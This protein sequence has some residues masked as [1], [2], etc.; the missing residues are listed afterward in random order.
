M[1]E[2]LP[3][4]QVRVSQRAR[5]V[6]LNIT[7]EKGLI[8]TIPRGFRP[9]LLP[10]MLAEKQDWI[11]KTIEKLSQTEPAAKKKTL[12]AEFD[13]VSIGEKWQVVYKPREVKTVSLK[14]QA[15][16]VLMVEGR[17]TSHPA[18]RSLLRRWLHE[19]A[20]QVL[21]EWLERISRQLKLPY[22]DV[23]IRDQRTRW[24]SCSA[25]KNISLNQKLL[26][27]PPDLV[28]YILVHELCHTIQMSHSSNYWKLVGQIM[29]DYKE[30]RK[31]LRVYEK[32][33]EW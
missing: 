32:K 28:E 2:S 20:E 9:E 7:R 24:G 33:I 23:S 6:R 22:Q 30:R 18:V 25:Q 26:F 4:Y 3:P 19:R 8:V 17:V 11:E 27:L 5:M 16:H 1:S 29:P 12:P 14:V 13:L 10:S 21:P 31:Q 15:R